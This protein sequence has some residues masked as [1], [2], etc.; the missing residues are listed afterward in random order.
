MIALAVA[1]GVA[2]IT[3]DRAARRN[4]LATTD[5][6]HL[7][8]VAAAVPADAHVVVLASGV[9]GVFCAGADLSDIARLAQHVPA[10]TAFRIAMREGIDAV[11]A[12]PMPVIAAVDGACLG[13]GVALA[14][15]ADVIV[16]GPSARFA[17]PPAR[18]G[19]SYPAPDVARLAA[20]VGQGAAARLLFGAEAI[21]ADEAL[22]I[23]L[24]DAI[25][26][27]HEFAAAVAAND[28]AALRLLKAALLTPADP[29]HD[30]AFEA[31]FGSARFAAATA[32][33]RGE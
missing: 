10:R 23:G 5:W 7:A 13:A 32:H 25:G 3:L 6:R 1:G 14:L 9:P 29:A 24:A 22:R 8:A 17:V 31:S 30:A 33:R 18:L 20:R 21:D 27:G 4:A 28:A 26:S 12:L 15:A 16:A 11:A 19:I 2:T